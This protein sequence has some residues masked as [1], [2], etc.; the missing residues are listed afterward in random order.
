MGEYA[1]YGGESVKIGTCEDMYYLRYDQ[2]HMVQPEPNSLNP[3]DPAIVPELRFRFP[4]PSEDGQ[5]PGSFEASYKHVWVPGLTAPAH[6][7]HGNVQ[8]TAP[9]GY[10]CSLPCPEGP[11]QVE[12]VHIHR[13][14][15]N[16]AVQ[17]VAQKLV[18]GV[19]LVPVLRC[20][21]CGAMWR[22]EDESEIER[23]AVAFRSEGDRR[24]RDGRFHGTGAADRR[25]WD[26]VADRVLAGIAVPAGVGA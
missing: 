22:E 9:A 12:G 2:R 16:G 10:L 15:F 8:F 11:G 17:L 20:G 21:G 23:I 7:E 1:R 26:Q 5:A 4:W 6:V 18:P 14:G 3:A 19:G 13:N 24:E 25:W